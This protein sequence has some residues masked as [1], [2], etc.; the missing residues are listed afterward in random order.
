MTVEIYVFCGGGG[1][2][3]DWFLCVYLPRRKLSAYCRLEQSGEFFCF[4][5]SAE[6]CCSYFCAR[7]YECDTVFTSNSGKR[8]REMDESN[9]WLFPWN[10]REGEKNGVDVKGG[11]RYDE[12]IK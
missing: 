5:V 6:N 1:V 3:V 7:A 4:L 12:I 11:D 10:W 9:R 8:W 2:R